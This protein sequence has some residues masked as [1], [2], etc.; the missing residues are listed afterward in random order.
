MGYLV[1]STLFFFRGYVHGDATL[2]MGIVLI[3]LLLR[4]F[5]IGQK[6]WR[7]APVVALAVGICCLRPE[8]SW[9]FILLISALLFTTETIFGRLNAAIFMV[10]LIVSPIFKYFSE[11]FT[12]PIRLQLSAVAGS[13][14]KM[15]GLPV[16]IEGNNILLNGSEFSVDPA[17][18]GLQMTGFALLSVIFLMAHFRMLNQKSLPI[19]YQTILVVL[20]F[21]LNI[22][23]NLM[24]IVSL[25]VLRI[26]PDNTLHDVIG[27]VC[28]VAYVI[29]PLILVVRYAHQ[30]WGAAL[31]TTQPSVLRHPPRFLI[32]GH[33]ILLSV[34][35]FFCFQKPT[36]N[37]SSPQNTLPLSLQT[38]HVKKLQN[39]VTQAR[40]GHALIYIKPIPAFYS[41]EHSPLTCWTGS[42]YH[43]SRISS[44]HL[45]GVTVYTGSL[46]KENDELHTAWWFSDGRHVTISQFDWRWKVL[47][48]KSHFQ[49]INVT[50]EDPARL[51]AEVKRWL[52]AF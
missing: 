37:I 40:N 18:I 21:A 36:I 5:G 24:R 49:L 8:L 23:G 28:L 32:T 16:A 13:M 10:L 35:A 3:P 26:T 15:A 30:R 4:C 27:V 9:R 1:I 50:V 17:C 47:A 34:C 12:F 20:A 39:G 19:R 2:W 51:D 22:L 11:V 38:Y 48:E 52:K 33:I 29:A 45:A 41:S 46:R 25:V 7:L 31:I 44:K 14:L 42:G 6:S 43:L